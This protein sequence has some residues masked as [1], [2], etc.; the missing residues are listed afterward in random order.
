M[1]KIFTIVMLAL[2]TASA[3]WAV[4][5]EEVTGVYAGELNIGGMPYSREVYVLPGTTDNTVTLVIPD[6]QHNGAWGDVVLTNV[7]I[8]AGGS[9]SMSTDWYVKSRSE[10]AYCE[11]SSATLSANSASLTMSVSTPTLPQS[12]SVQFAGNRV[13]D[14]NYDFYNGGFEGAWTNNEPSGWHSFVSATGS[15]SRFVSGNTDQFE[16]SGEIRPGSTGSQ[17]AMIA[18][19]SVLGARAN[20]NCTNGQINAGSMSATEAKGNYNF[21]D[22]NN[23]GYNTPFA[24]SPDSVVFWA[25]Y[26]PADRKP[27]NEKNVASAHAVLTTNARYQDPEAEDDD[28]SSVKVAEAKI[29]YMA[30]ANLG[31]QRLAMP[32]QYTAI[33]PAQTAYMLITFTTN[34]TP[35][36][37]TSDANNPDKIYLDDAEMIYNHSLVSLQM[38]GK[39]VVFS[40][41]QA[42]SD[43]AFS[44]SIYDFAADADGKS[45]QSYI[46]YDSENNRVYVYVLAGNFAQARAY[47]LYTLQ[48]TEPEPPVR[49]TEYSYAASTCDNEPYSD[50]LFSNLTAAGEYTV[51]I[52]N[53][54]GGDS[55][56]TLTLSILPTYSFATTAAIGT[57]D[58]ITWRG[59]T[60]YGMA[61]TVEPYLY[62]DSLTTV[63]GCDSVYV[64]ELHVSDNLTYGSYAA[65]FC[66]GDSIEYEGK[67]YSQAYEGDVILKG[68]NSQGGDSIV[69]LIVTVLPNFITHEYLTITE[70]DE[71][72]WEGWDLSTIPAGESELVAVYYTVDDCDSTIVI[73]LTVEPQSTEALDPAAHESAQRQFR[74]VLYNGRLYIIRDDETVYDILGT[75]IQ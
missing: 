73:H 39:T 19:H 66:E 26:I 75:K 8:N 34:A 57:Q 30:T 62:Y 48:L 23:S 29:E 41:N 25:K 68:R 36:G 49:D 67:I 18:T 15:F 33:D 72:S 70:G 56:I 1:K 13:A 2:T 35:G 47:S 71:Q 50:D 51:T 69:H 43:L 40:G 7:A 5:V 4:T 54:Q 22:P 61:E 60:I 16:Q 45:A 52:P 38:D 12:L 20:G 65:Q 24:G 17:S 14:R 11:S 21:S 58:T 10:R 27:S 6:F 3:A 63:A 53:T 37:G 46:A 44:D 31:W 42:A 9:L 74:K 28:Y 55:V 64:L 59:Q 32:F